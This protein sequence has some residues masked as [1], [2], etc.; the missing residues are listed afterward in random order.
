MFKF[1]GLELKWAP[2][3]I[4]SIFVTIFIGLIVV[5]FI[6]PSNIYQGIIENR[7]EKSTG[8]NVEFIGDFSFSLLP[9][10][11]LEADDL[12]FDGE[13]AS[14]VET[15]GTV[16]HIVLEISFWKFLT[17]NIHIHDFRLQAPKATINGDFLR[18]IP[19]WIRKNLRKAHKK[20]IRYEEIFLYLVEE[21]VFDFIEISEGTLLWNKD[22]DK[23][24]SVEKIRLAIEKPAEGKDF[25]IDLNSYV[26]DRAVDIA[27]RLQRPGEFIRGFR[28]KLSLKLDSSPLR[29]LF[30]GTAAHRQSFVAQGNTHLEVP[31]VYEFCSWFN[32][33]STCQNDQGSIKIK[34]TLKL[35]DQRLQIEDATYHNGPFAL[36]ANA[37]ID[38]KK[39]MPVI[40]GT[41]LVPPRPLSS[42]AGA[43]NSLKNVNFED[44]LLDTFD[45]DIDLKYQ[46]LDMAVG[47]IFKPQVKILIKSGRLSISAD[48]LGVF[49]G[50]S[51]FRLR[52]HKGIDQGYM[53]AR[54]DAN[55][56]D[57]TSLQNEF[58]QD[59]KLTGELKLSFEIQS[60]G[61]HP[62]ALLETAR[63]HG[64]FSVLDGALL[65]PDVIQSLL[66]E[67]AKSFDFTELTGRLKGDR[68]QITAR[69]IK[70]TTPFVDVTGFGKYDFLANSLKVQI[71]SR[72]PE[73]LS[74]DGT[75]ITPA[76]EGY[77]TVL[78][79]NGAFKLNTSAK[80]SAQQPVQ[81]GLH[82][83]FL[84]YTDVQKEDEMGIEIEES[85][86][87]D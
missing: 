3:K 41:L 44:L 17:G 58:E 56:I 54:F 80:P 14:G 52:W 53:D 1:E 71:N 32:E 24:V 16:D 20:D 81:E 76:H 70:F 43:F 34:S 33:A 55:S 60:L 7:L 57:I 36:S 61:S 18:Y 75:K 11:R 19:D 49:G 73:R 42:F 72:I 28:S 65:Q 47:D 46:G 15:V 22:T 85:D 82:S 62:I 86:L 21:S 63:V 66:G 51:N 78:R 13:L 39:T 45:A 12:E 9:Y 40:I 74:A 68:G 48:Q 69:D 30:D 59:F 35:R 67:N 87:L 5:P 6:L 8:L 84:P 4:V 23:T 38:F 26:N 10:I 27:M 83:G 79:E 2:S 25:T 77:I 31:S 37:I 64:E 29:L 50:L